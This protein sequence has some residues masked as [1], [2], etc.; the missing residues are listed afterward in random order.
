MLQQN[1]NFALNPREE[2]LDKIKD[3]EKRL[4]QPDIESKFSSNE[5]ELRKF[6]KYRGQWTIYVETVKNETLGELVERL[7]QN[8]THF[9]AGIEAINQEIQNLNNTV[10]FLNL[11]ERTIGIL[12]RII[13]LTV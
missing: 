3:I 8:E 6:K 9:E 2:F 11:F 1:S 4:Y 7:E 12:G 10:S 13:T 5:L